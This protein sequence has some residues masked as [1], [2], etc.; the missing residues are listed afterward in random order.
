MVG[1]GVGHLGDELR[2]LF[3]GD[4]GKGPGRDVVHVDVRC[5]LNAVGLC[6]GRSAG[7]DVHGHARGG[8][9]QGKVADIDVHASGIAAPGLFQG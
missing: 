9:F 4:L 1:D 6:G 2:K 5:Q 7:V 3:L 8:Q